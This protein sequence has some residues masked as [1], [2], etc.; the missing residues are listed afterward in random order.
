MSDKVRNVFVTIVFLSI[1]IGF[2]IVSIIKK[3]T[4][5]SVTERRK[6]ATFPKISIQTIINGDFAD[7]FENYTMDQF[8]YRDKFRQAKTFVELNLFGKNDIDN[9]Y[10][11]DDM[12]IKQEYPLNEKS[13][14]N[15]TKKINNIKQNYLDDTNNVYYTIIPDKNYYVENEKYL[16]ID[17]SKVEEVLSKHLSNMEYIN[18]LDCLS[19][20][21]FYYT[22]THWKQENLGKVFDKISTYMNFNDRI[23][24]KFY[25]VEISKFNGVYSG[26]L[27]VKNKEDTI[28]ILTNDII[29]NAK[30][31]NHENKKTTKIYDLEKLKSNDKYDIF[32]SGA[33]PLLTIENEKTTTNRELIVFRD[34]Y[35]SS[36]IPLFIEGYSKITVVDTRYISTS[37][38]GEYIDFK[39]KDVLF[40]YSILVIN[41]SGTLK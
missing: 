38:L 31:Y 26:K 25:E 27:K 2:F 13:V 36:L 29:E 16:K 41:N 18:I 28:K 33:T 9:L 20:E 30:V 24:N 22:D 21:D 40:M 39:N 32:L 4:L 19:L 1:I 37:L 14:L 12:L 23:K 11:Y 8:I 5:I 10:V 34:S 35:G 17:Y 6:L 15:I 7:G 3:D